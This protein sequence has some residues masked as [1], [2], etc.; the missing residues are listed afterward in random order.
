[1]R[2][3]SCPPGS[4]YHAARARR[5]V[6]ALIDA[7]EG[8]T[9]RGSWLSLWWLVDVLTFV[10]LVAFGVCIAVL[11][12]F[13]GEHALAQ[14]HDLA[15]KLQAE[16]HRLPAPWYAPGKA[17]ETTGERHYRLAVIAYAAAAE[18]T[19]PDRLPPSWRAEHLAWAAFVIA[20]WE[21]SRFA[22]EVHD[23]SKRGDRGRSVCLGQVQ[24]SGLVPPDEW[25]A[26]PGTELEAT[27]RCFAAIV[28]VFVAHLCRCAK[29]E[30]PSFDV[31]TRAM[32]GYGTGYSCSAEVR[33]ADGNYWA[34]DRAEMWA[35][36]AM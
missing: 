23:G 9:G 16:A 31:V 2:P 32:A 13:M 12:I 25:A 29:G 4:R 11:L 27:R 7:G 8:F 10:A 18:A 14:P 5:P 30:P 35:R 22:L 6:Q 34:K 21:G 24:T 1:M 17:P 15:A 3:L 26:L 20:Y 28:R 36:L 33:D 19:P